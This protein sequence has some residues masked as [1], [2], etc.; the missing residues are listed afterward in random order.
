MPA[1]RLSSL[2][3]TVTACVMSSACAQPEPQ[4][5]VS[6]SCLTFKRISA[7][8]DPARINTGETSAEDDL[9]GN[10]FDTEQTYG[11]IVSHNEVY[12]RLCAAR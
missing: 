6:D 10:Q 12:D 11:E 4:R 1:M 3:L 9:P 7:E 8:P 5:T 2:A